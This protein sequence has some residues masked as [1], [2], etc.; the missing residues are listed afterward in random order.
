MN[1]ELLPNLTDYAKKRRMKL[2][3]NFFETTVP[4]STK[5]C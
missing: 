2:K 1:F 4:V 3:K 5:L